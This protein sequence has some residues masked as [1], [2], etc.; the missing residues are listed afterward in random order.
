MLVGA[1]VLFVGDS[2]T[3]G[4]VAD[5]GQGF[6]EL[7]GAAH[8]HLTVHNAGCSGSSTRDWVLPKLPVSP[9]ECAFRGAF[10][11]LAAPHVD[12]DAVHILLGTN[13][14][15]GVFEDERTSA[16]DYVDNISMLAARFPGD[17]I[18]SLPPPLPDPDDPLQPL[19]DAYADALLMRVAVGG[20]PF[21]IGADFRGLDRASLVGVH[22]TN[23]G[24]AW[25]AAQ[26]VGVIVP[27]PHSAAL[28][29]VGLVVLARSRQWTCRKRGP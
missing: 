19:L 14:A 6:V 3:A 4:E 10:E 13:D 28:V 1:Q 15:V 17:V 8:P 26:L 21:R 2:I 9:P 23:A 11:L 16:G 22:P 24:H 12:A 7:W 18:V 5:P 27:E 20:A 29:V 25:M